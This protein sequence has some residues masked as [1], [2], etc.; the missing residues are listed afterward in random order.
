M[1]LV[2][3]PLFGRIG[4]QRLSR[5]IPYSFHH[6]QAFSPTL[7]EQNF[8]SNGQILWALDKPECHCST[9]TSPDEVPVNINDGTCLGHRT[10]MQHCLVLRFDGGGMAEDQY[11]GD[12]LAEDLGRRRCTAR[13]TTCRRGMV[14]QNDHSFSYILPAHIPERKASR[15]PR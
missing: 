1:L 15:L 3:F 11:F 10:N 12:E 7:S 4:I 14:V 8:V 13:Q 2:P 6:P 5:V 9:V